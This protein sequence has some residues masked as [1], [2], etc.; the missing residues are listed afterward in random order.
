MAKRE[1]KASIHCYVDEELKKEAEALF[2]MVGLT[3]SE[4][5]SLFLRKCVSSNGL[6]FVVKM[7]ED[8]LKKLRH[9]YL[10]AKSRRAHRKSE[11][12]DENN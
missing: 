3:M 4:A 5:I 7:K 1:G 2:D 10:A 12:T 8:E 9:N 6:P 11:D